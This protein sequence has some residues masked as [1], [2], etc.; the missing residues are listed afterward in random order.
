MGLMIKELLAIG[1]RRL[2][3]ASCMDARLDAELL[4]CDLLK[5]GRS[6]LFSHI[7]DE[8]D[9]RR[10]EF[11]FEQIDIRATGKPLQ[12]ILGNQEFMGLRFQVNEDVLIPR[13]DTET[14]VETALEYLKDTK[15]PMGGFEILDL[16]CGSGAIAISLAYYLG[17]AKAKITAAD[18]SEKA[19]LIA[20]ENA[21]GYGPAKGIS[22]VH[23]DL[24]EAFPKNRKGRGKRQ[25]DLIVSNPPYICSDVIPTLQREVACFEPRMALDGGADGLDFYRRIAKDA[26]NYLKTNGLMLLEIGHDQAE[27]V[28]QF[29]EESNFFKTVEVKKDLAGKDR[30][31]WA[32]ADK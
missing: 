17:T 23:S 8:L 24:F 21:S 18:Y 25:F 15:T 5:R 32:K 12:Y 6:F 30:I 29:L 13:Q 27:E 11:Y 2:S 20:K 10:C 26:E 28:I 4:L 14:L 7:G 3:D 31:I 1:E 19:L 9:D 22:F 16:C